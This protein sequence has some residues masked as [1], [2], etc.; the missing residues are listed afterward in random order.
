MM[1]IRL[2]DRKAAPRAEW[3]ALHAYRRLRLEEDTPGEPLY[4]DADFEADVRR[5][6]PLWESRRLMAW[7]DG[8]VV[9]NCG[10]SFRR[11][12]SPDFAA[13]A[14]YV[15]V[16]GGVLRPFRRQGIATALLRATLPFIDGMGKTVISAGTALPEGH[17][18][19]A[20]VGFAEKHRSVENRL[21]LAA[22]DW[23]MVAA[24]QAAEV[25]AG[26]TRE[27]HSGRAPLG[28][29]EA[30]YPQFTALLQTVPLG[31][32]ETPPPRYE[33]AATRVWYDELERHGGAHHLVLLMAGATVAGM[34]EA[35]ADARFPDRVFQALTAVAPAWRGLGLGKWLKAKMLLLVRTAHPQA[36]LVITSNANVNAPML[37]INQRLGFRLHRQDSAWQISRAA[38]G[39]YLAGEA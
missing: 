24:W 1:E 17:A 5:D 15:N 37:S 25:P 32:L 6:W 9:G 13:H 29:L 39:R 33:I 27:I 18:F 36:R 11:P 30:L 12:G 7:R 10:H 20:A 2:F 14:A 35:H 23:E 26:L 16:W 38:L 4:P 34:C 22:L 19:M 28:R 3:E 8:S 31:A 21:D